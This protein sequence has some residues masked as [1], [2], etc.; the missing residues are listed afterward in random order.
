VAHRVDSK[1]KK[2]KRKTKRKKNKRR[3][4][5]MKLIACRALFWGSTLRRHMHI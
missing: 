2:N 3:R 1:K 4:R 5:R